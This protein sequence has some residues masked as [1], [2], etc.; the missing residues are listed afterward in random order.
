MIRRGVTRLSSRLRAERPSGSLAG[1]K[2]VVLGHLNR[3][4]PSSAGAIAAAANL[5]PQSLTRTFNELQLAGLIGRSQDP[6]DRRAAVL[7]LTETGR[8]ALVQDM[9][10]RD[11]WLE[12][13]L[14]SLTEA[15]AEILRIAAGLMERLAEPAPRSA[16]SAREEAETASPAA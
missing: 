11:E 7:T 5:Q 15:E 2:V 16:V 14:G 6:H 13:A 10:A 12:E 1:T 4:G 9:S 8:Q 3:Y